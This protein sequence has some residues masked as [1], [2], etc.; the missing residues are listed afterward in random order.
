MQDRADLCAAFQSAVTDILTEKSRRALALYL[1]L[2][3]ATPSFAVAGGVAANQPI[4][5]ALTAWPT[6]TERSSSLH[7]SPFAPTM[8][9]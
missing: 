4:R 6:V 5:A 2:Q 1:T 9:R 8:A 3:P 7:R